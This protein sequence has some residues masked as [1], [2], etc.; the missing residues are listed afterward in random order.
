MAPKHSKA[1]RARAKAWGDVIDAARAFVAEE[2]EKGERFD[3]DY[4]GNGSDFSDAIENYAR[5]LHR[6]EW[7]YLD[8]QERALKR[9]T[10]VLLLRI[11]RAI[12]QAD[13]FYKFKVEEAMDRARM[14]LER[15]L[16]LAKEAAEQ[17]PSDWHEADNSLERLTKKQK[18]R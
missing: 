15:A 11:E 14:P 12:E 5:A 10:E 16:K 8:I 9:L 13:E 4:Y 18:T 7:A 1:W 3:P 2:K 6:D 17:I